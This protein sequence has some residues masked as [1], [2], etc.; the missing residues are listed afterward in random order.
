[1]DYGPT[2]PHCSKPVSPGARFCKFCGSEI[3]SGTSEE[4]V[5]ICPR[6]KTQNKG[7]ARFCKKCGQKL[8]P[9]P[10]KNPFSG[11]QAEYDA[12]LQSEFAALEKCRAL[13]YGEFLTH[14][15]ELS[16]HVDGRIDELVARAGADGSS[17]FA[18]AFGSHLKEGRKMLQEKV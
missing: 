17:P 1:M 12:F 2:C 18:D 10:P 5:L 3:D 4:G 16:S 7:T 13:P 11:I 8:D 15:S 14:A 6:C 9:L